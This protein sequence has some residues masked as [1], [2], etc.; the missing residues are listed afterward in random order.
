MLIK[1]L[2]KKLS[3]TD[4]QKLEF[5]MNRKN[6]REE[7][8]EIFSMFEKY[9]GEKVDRSC[10]KCRSETVFKMLKVLKVRL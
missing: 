7:Q 3:D 5:L 2:A 9:V 1:D 8:E 4:V 6:Y 10:G